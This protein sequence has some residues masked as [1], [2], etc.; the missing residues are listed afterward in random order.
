[1][2]KSTHEDDE[3]EYDPEN[4]EVINEIIARNDDEFELFDEMDKNRK[5]KE[6]NY[7]QGQGR[8]IRDSRQPDWLDYPEQGGLYMEYGYGK[9]IRRQVNQETYNDAHLD[10]LL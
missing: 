7:Y 9:R 3:D 2:L 6:A 4:D 10:R 8:L 1:M 5:K